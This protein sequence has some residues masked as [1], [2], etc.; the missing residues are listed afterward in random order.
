MK[1]ELYMT[2]LLG[3]FNIN[4]ILVHCI[5]K[6][7]ELTKKKK[8]MNI[9]NIYKRVHYRSILNLTFELKEPIRPLVYRF[10]LMYNPCIDR[11]EKPI[12]YKKIDNG[13][14]YDDVIKFL[15]HLNLIKKGCITSKSDLSNK[16][17]TLRNKNLLKMKMV[18]EIPYYSVTEEAQRLILKNLLN[19][20]YNKMSNKILLN[21][22][23]GFINGDLSSIIIGF[24]QNFPYL[25]NKNEENEINYLF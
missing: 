7:T 22:T 25:T 4:Y 20:E 11:F 17:K 24:Y 16:L 13:M 5:H 2:W 3:Y 9:E 6:N 12:F 15:I 10:A 1:S 8:K 18:D 23:S 19:A 14:S 21:I